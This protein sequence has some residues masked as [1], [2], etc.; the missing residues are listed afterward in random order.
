MVKEKSIETRLRR[1]AERQGLR[2]ERCRRRDTRALAYG[3]YRLA[4]A[5]TGNVVASN[6][7]TGYGLT[8]DQIER[9]LT[10]GE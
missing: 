6:G 2:L 3:T 9:Y 5:T 7:I 8:L 1:M 10:R 4:D